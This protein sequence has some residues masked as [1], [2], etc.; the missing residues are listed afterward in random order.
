M[1]RHHTCWSNV[2]L[3]HLVGYTTPFRQG[4][5]EQ[6]QTNME[7][8]PFGRMHVP[9]QI[10]RI[11]RNAAFLVSEPLLNWLQI[12]AKR[13]KMI[14]LPGKLGTFYWEKMLMLNC[15]PNILIE[16]VQAKVL[17]SKTT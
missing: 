7:I 16:P 9:E 8:H 13:K 2:G 14:E 6:F 11:N 12:S 10:I 15:Y 3:A 17:L 1:G 4:P 5:G